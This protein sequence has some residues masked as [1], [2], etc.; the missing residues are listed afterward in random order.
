MDGGRQWVGDGNWLG[1]IVIIMSS[2]EEKYLKA[3]REI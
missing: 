2:F 3:L 1:F